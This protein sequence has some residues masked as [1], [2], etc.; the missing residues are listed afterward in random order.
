VATNSPATTTIRA[1]VMLSCLIVVPALAVSGKSLPDTLKGLADT[2]RR[3]AALILSPEAQPKPPAATRQAACPAP[4]LPIVPPRAAPTEPR[5]P[6]VAAPLSLAAGGT[7]PP[8]SMAL[9]AYDAP[10]AAD[11]DPVERPGP[12]VGSPPSLPNRF[13]H[14][15]QRL[16]AQGATYYLLESWGR[17]QELHRFFCRVAVADSPRYTRH[18]EATD[19]DPLVAMAEVLSEI[20]AWR[21]RR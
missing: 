8:P 15:E 20:E 9:A 16:Q 4:V 6:T 13:A 19:V 17:G 3:Q 11:A 18:F 10:G 12:D 7:I 14:V 21:A 5:Q 2:G 1:L